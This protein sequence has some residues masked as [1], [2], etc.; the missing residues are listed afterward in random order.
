MGGSGHGAGCGF[1][2]VMVFI[3][4]LVAGTGCSLTS[5]VLLDMESVGMDGVT[6][7]FEKPLFQ[8]LGMFVGMCAALILHAGVR[9]FK[10]PF[11]GYVHA[12]KSSGKG[13]S[14]RVGYA[15]VGEVGDDDDEDDD[16]EGP[17]AIPVWM[18]SAD[19]VALLFCF[20][21]YFC[22]NAGAAMKIIN[23]VIPVA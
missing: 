4:A 21:I 13:R 9:I 6:K 3:L 12:K 19:R 10:I 20:G 23:C 2:E 17:Q 16:D 18:V 14:K 22:S 15:A 11:P 5:K 8:T 7:K 1:A